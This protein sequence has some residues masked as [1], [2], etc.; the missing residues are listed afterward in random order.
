MV[1]RLIERRELS[2]RRACELVGIDHSVLHYRFRRSDDAPLRQRLRELAQVRRRFGYR[3]LGWLLAREGHAMNH[4]KLYRLYREEK[5]MVRRRRGRKR[6]LGARA[7]LP[8]AQAVNQRWSL[9]FVSDTLSDGR[10]FRIL[11]MVDNF[12]REC[13]ATVVDS[14]LSGV[15][16]VRQLEQLIRDRGTPKIIVSDNGAELT[17]LAVLRWVPGRVAWHYI[18][19]GQPAQNAF[20]ESFN[21]RFR[22][23]CL[24]EH[25]FLRLA[26]AREIIEA[27]RHDYN[28]LRPHSSLG[29]LTPSEF[30]DRQGAGPPEQVWGSAA[31]PL[32][33]PPQ[34]R[35]NINSGPYS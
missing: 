30:A 2:Q 16:V 19:P 23:E 8:S 31:R 6:A 12:S 27:W 24:N 10:R 28:C 3:R 32:A 5:L 15:R 1:A 34:P 29:A 7:P 14:S 35:H 4:K 18:E 25:V 11:C 26:E 13:L 22:D 33:P 9:D 17:S 21:S 20:I